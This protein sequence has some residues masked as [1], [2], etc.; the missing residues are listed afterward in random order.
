M[1][2]GGGGGCGC[3]LEDGCSQCSSNPDANSNGTLYDFAKA[4]SFVLS[5]CPVGDLAVCGSGGGG[6]GWSTASCEYVLQLQWVA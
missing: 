6:G 4:L 3:T 1:S 2:I 5:E